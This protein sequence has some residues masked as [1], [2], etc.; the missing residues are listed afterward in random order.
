MS[1]SFVPSICVRGDFAPRVRCTTPPPP[2]QRVC[3]ACLLLDDRAYNTRSPFHPDCVCSPKCVICMRTGALFFFFHLGVNSLSAYIRIYTHIHAQ[4]KKK[5]VTQQCQYRA[6]PSPTRT[7]R[8]MTATTATA[9][10]TATPGNHPHP[11]PRL[12]RAK[13]LKASH[14][15]RNS[16]NNSQRDRELFERRPHSARPA[17]R[18]RRGLRL[19]LLLHPRQRRKSLT[20]R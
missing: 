5:K 15:T 4:K 14:M 3:I 8:A 9:T 13:D 10:A 1:P 12:A 19:H 16:N 6:A 18:R 17:R 20:R 11:I 7:H 2:P